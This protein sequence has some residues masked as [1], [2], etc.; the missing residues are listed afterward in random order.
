MEARLSS[1]ITETHSLPTDRLVDDFKL[2]AQRAGQK[3]RE[4][5]QAADRAVRDHPYQT[6]GIALGLGVLIGVLAGRRWTLHG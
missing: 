5:A 3:A 1:P 2:V 4:S 6:L